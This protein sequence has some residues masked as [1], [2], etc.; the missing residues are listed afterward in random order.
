MQNG[1]SIYYNFKRSKIDTEEYVTNL[2]KYIH[3][4]PVKHGVAKNV[5]EWKF[6]SYNLLCSDGK[7]FLAKSRTLEWFGGLEEF[8]KY[9]EDT[10]QLPIENF[11]KG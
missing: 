8:K 4:N 3:L 2:I 9:H 1:K 5:S 11:R 7:T 6:S 10:R